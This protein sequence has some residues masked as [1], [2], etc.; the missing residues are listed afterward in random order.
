MASVQQHVAQW[1]HN[2]KFAQ[3]IDRAYR[4]W[5]INVIFYAAL[6]A[7]D[8]ALTHL[9]V[10]VT[11]HET[12]NQAVRNNASLSGLRNNDLDLYRISKV[13]RYDADPDDWLPEQYLSVGDLVDHLLTPIERQVEALLGKTLGLAAI[14]VRE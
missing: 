3:A 8:A 12:R 7:V 9:G 4:D 10:P 14:R 2:R 13:T 11:N 6:H 1:K 5:Q